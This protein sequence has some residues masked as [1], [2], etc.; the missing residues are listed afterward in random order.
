V[1]LLRILKLS[2]QVHN[3]LWSM[4]VL[5]TQSKTT[6]LKKRRFSRRGSA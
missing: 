5:M 1:S 4:K 3:Q 6:R 2:V